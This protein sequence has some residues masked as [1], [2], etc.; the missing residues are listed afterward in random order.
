MWLR[1]RATRQ[2]QRF[3]RQ[4]S[5]Y[6]HHPTADPSPPPALLCSASM[7]TSQRAS[8][9]SACRR[10]GCPSRSL[11]TPNPM[12][13][14][15]RKGDRGRRTCTRGVHPNSGAD[16]HLVCVIHYF[17]TLTLYSN[18]VS[19]R[20]P[21]RSFVDSGQEPIYGGR[22][23]RGA[24]G[25]Q[26][27]GACVV[28]APPWPASLRSF[29]RVR[30]LSSVAT[31]CSPLRTRRCAR[32]WKSMARRTGR[33]SR[34]SCRR[35]RTCSACTGG[36][37]CS[38]RGWSRCARIAGYALRPARA[39]ARVLLRRSSAPPTAAG[40]TLP[41]PHPRARGRPRRT[42]RCGGSWRCTAQRSGA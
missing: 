25:C 39:H 9:C 35:V 38:S 1:C 40:F 8:P 26:V 10:S 34:R 29:A 15:Q 3:L 23:R 2:S 13:R 21:P 27:A 28:V 36:R 30:T 18:S 31:L 11:G 33:R 20:G 16:V 32:P 4:S 5:P 42:S 12:R 17:V 24:E 14:R 19:D 41:H 22:R 7:P 6:P 37:R